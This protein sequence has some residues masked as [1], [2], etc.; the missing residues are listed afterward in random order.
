MEHT[1]RIVRDFKPLTHISFET[2]VTQ[3]DPNQH[4]QCFAASPVRAHERQIRVPKK[5]ILGGMGRGS[6]RAHVT[7]YPY[8]RYIKSTNPIVRCVMSLT[9]TMKR[10]RANQRIP[11]HAVT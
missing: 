11:K 1:N 3:L 9:W 6:Y 2:F 5:G 10:M 7:V 8:N 4:I